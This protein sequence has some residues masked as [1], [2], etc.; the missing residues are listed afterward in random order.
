LHQPQYTTLDSTELAVK[1]LEHLLSSKWSESQSLSLL[2]VKE[3]VVGT[4]VMKQLSKGR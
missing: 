1:P 4:A 3:T 2:E